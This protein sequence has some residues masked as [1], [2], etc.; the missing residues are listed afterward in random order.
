MASVLLLVRA[1][2]ADRWYSM[3]WE[4][5]H[6]IIILSVCLSPHQLLNV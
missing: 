4:N 5:S 2:N 3:L 1:G 6:K